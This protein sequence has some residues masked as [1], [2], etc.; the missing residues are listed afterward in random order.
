[1][2]RVRGLGDWSLVTFV[3]TSGCAP[4]AHIP[5]PPLS[6]HQVPP[7]R[8][9]GWG[10]KRGRQGPGPHSKRAMWKL[11]WLGSVGSLSP[12]AE[13]KASWLPEKPSQGFHSKHF[14]PM[15][16]THQRGH[17]HTDFPLPSQPGAQRQRKG[18]ALP[19]TPSFQSSQCHPGN[20]GSPAEAGRPAKPSPP[21]LQPGPA[22]AC[23]GPLPEPVG[24]RPCFYFC[25]HVLQMPLL[26]QQS[27]AGRGD[28]GEEV[29]SASSHL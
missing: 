22:W 6:C 16:L 5:I 23:P 8:V 4:R 1:M 18:P 11:G 13:P 12:L 27:V 21:A 9:G 3:M 25:A 29:L 26:A 24:G 2:L 14:H 17:S 15:A 28:F 7:C 20:S 10:P 19:P